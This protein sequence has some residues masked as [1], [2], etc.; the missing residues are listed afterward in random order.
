[1]LP[2]LE[3]WASI[4]FIDNVSNIRELLTLY[5]ITLFS[6][7]ELSTGVQKSLQKQ[8]IWNNLKAFIMVAQFSAHNNLHLK[9]LWCFS[10]IISHLKQ[11]LSESKP[12]FQ[13]QNNLRLINLCKKDIR[14]WSI[15]YVKRAA[16][17]IL[18]YSAPNRNFFGI[19]LTLRWSCPRIN[20]SCSKRKKH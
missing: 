11:W 13:M 16:L 15:A 6:R 14:E 18:F 4:S 2:Q 1:M 19:A 3:S 10:I 8:N 17:S 5:Y 20:N 12:D 7:K 9:I